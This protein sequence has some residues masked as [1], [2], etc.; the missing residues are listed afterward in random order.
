MSVR[1]LSYTGPAVELRASWCALVLA[2]LF[3]MLVLLPSTTRADEAIPLSLGQAIELAKSRSQLLV[4]QQAA[5]AAARQM[6]IAAGKVPDPILTVG[7]NNLPV[8]GP[9]AWSLTDDFMTMRSIGVMQEF[10]RS[11]KRTARAARYEREADLAETGS[12]IAL[13]SIQSG[14][15]LAWLDVHFNQRIGTF[16][17]A[18][19]DEA[20]LQIEAADAAYRAARGPQA[21][22]FAARSAVAQIEDRVAQ[23]DAEVAAAR[24]RLARW[25]G[26]AASRPLGETPSAD[27]IG[28]DLQQ[29]DAQLAH[30]P[31]ITM[32][33]RQEELSLAE[34]EI[35]RA[36][37]QA[38]WSAA[39]MYSQR[40][41]SYSNMISV[42]FSFPLQWDQ[43]DRQDRE[44][45]A[46]LALVDQARAQ[47]EET[48]RE[49]VAEVRVMV[50][51][52]QSKRQRL[53]RYDSNLIPLAAERTRAALSAYRTGSTALSSVLEARRNA[54]DV[55]V[56]R[57]RLE[58]ES[59]RLWAQLNFLI[60]RN[61]GA[62]KAIR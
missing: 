31:Q 19:Q 10:T 43:K 4:A 52:W 61:D 46:K 20:G 62:A 29:L 34:A 27:S 9:D 42:N 21:D 45:A 15:A 55:G 35:A 12:V 33:S 3:S 37:K 57:L 6:A 40:G 36:N 11:D 38:D 53:A 41:P 56:E 24:A 18:Q 22:V 28:L 7:V 1:V 48:L 30:H 39:L 54:I 47:R 32:L 60:P 44:V 25:I 50:L 13:I 16:L 51:E 26:P 58:L 23:N 8:N 59:A 17:L 5:A 2:V 14:T 49:H